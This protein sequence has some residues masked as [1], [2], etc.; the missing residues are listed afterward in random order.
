[1]EELLR[2]AELRQ[3]RARRVVEMSG[4]PAAWKAIGAEVAAVGSLRTGLLIDHRDIDFHVYTDTL[5]P[6]SAPT[7]Q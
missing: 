1:M 3:A 2:L 4:I 5:E 6:E 7:R